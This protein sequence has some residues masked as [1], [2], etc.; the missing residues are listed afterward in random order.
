M[1]P[2]YFADEIGSFDIAVG[3]SSS[4]QLPEIVQSEG[5]ELTEVILVLNDDQLAEY[6]AYNKETNTIDYAPDGI[7]QDQ[8]LNRKLDDDIINQFVGMNLF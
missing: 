7:A 8:D 2:L 5:M 3:L 6:F 4:M 1:L